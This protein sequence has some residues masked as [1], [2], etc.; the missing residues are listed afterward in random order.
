MG[1]GNRTRRLVP[2]YA[3][4]P[5]M[6][7]Q[8]LGHCARPQAFNEISLQ[9]GVDGA[10]IGGK[11]AGPSFY[12]QTTALRGP[13]LRV[14]HSQDV[15]GLYLSRQLPDQHVLGRVTIR[16]YHLG[17]PALQP[18]PEVFVMDD[19]GVRGAELVAKALYA[20][21]HRPDPAGQ[22]QLQVQWREVTGY[23]A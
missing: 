19:W 3:E 5:E 18:A 15:H 17:V 10:A 1:T 13:R 6:I 20:H 23:N 8:Y 7:A 4:S 12:K 22:L 14:T 9:S 21:L 2:R 16:C 11:Y